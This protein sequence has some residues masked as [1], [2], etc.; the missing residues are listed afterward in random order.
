MASN[1]T[2]NG[3]V[4]DMTDPGM[5]EL[6]LAEP[7]ISK[8]SVN[9]RHVVDR[10]REVRVP[11]RG[12][13]VGTNGHVDGADQVLIGPPFEVSTAAPS[14]PVAAHHLAGFDL[15]SVAAI[16]V[17]FS[18]CAIALVLAATVL[19]WIL[20]SMVGLVGAFE[21]FMRG[22]GF[23]GFHFLSIQLL[24]GVT[25]VAAVFGAFLVGMTLVAAALYNALAQRS[26][27]VRILVADGTR[28]VDDVVHNAP[29]ANGNGT[30]GNGANGNGANGNGANGNG[31][32]GNGAN[33]NGANGNGANGNGAKRVRR[34]SVRRS[35]SGADA[36]PART[37]P[38]RSGPPI[39]A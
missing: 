8:R 32:N 25:F 16:S 36:R 38:A 39:S 12:V 26:G 3:T 18:G 2:T 28:A 10:L 29:L 1:G 14:A 21:K 31:A 9:V 37:R 13:R 6:T 20:G 27:G 24:L 33:G 34:A 7:A 5:H 15:R 22:I 30:N 17:R 23:S 4:D 35:D 19:F 11:L